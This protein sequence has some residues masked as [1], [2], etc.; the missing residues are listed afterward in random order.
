MSEKRW[1]DQEEIVCQ[2]FQIGKSFKFN[3]NK[4]KRRFKK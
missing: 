1:I 4:S 3:D 2:E